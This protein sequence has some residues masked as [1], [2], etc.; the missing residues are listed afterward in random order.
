[1]SVHV[2]LSVWDLLYTGFVACTATSSKSLE[3]TKEH[4]ANTPQWHV[5]I[6]ET[7]QSIAGIA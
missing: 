6:D 7:N 5:I 1:M 3:I 2:V 4:Q